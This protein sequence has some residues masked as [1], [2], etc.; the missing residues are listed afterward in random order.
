MW[1]WAFG[2]AVLVCLPMFCQQDRILVRDI[3]GRVLS[4]SGITLVDWQGYMANPAIEF[5]VIPPTTAQFPATAVLTADEQRLY[6]DRPSTVGG[7]GAEKTIPF[8][9]GSTRVTVFL[10]NVPDRGSNDGFFHLHIPFV[11]ADGRTSAVT[12]PIHEIDQDRNDS[13][14]YQRS[15]DFS[16]DRTGFFRSSSNRSPVVQALND[17]AYF[18]DDMDVDAVLAG[19]ERTPIWGAEGFTSGTIVTNS[20]AYSGSLLYVYGIHSAALRS[21]GEPS[22]QGDF[23]R[24]TG[25]LCHSAVRAEWNRNGT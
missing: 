24:P 15:A 7:D 20:R 18:F 13:A 10:G 22:T 17:G 23:R 3:F 16:K 12:I 4:E 19:Q 25:S 2:L 1:R 6:L 11:G 9:D 14:H 21:G 8:A 5:V